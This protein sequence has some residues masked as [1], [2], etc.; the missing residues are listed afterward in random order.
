MRKPRHNVANRFSL[1][2]L[3]RLARQRRYPVKVLSL[4]RPIEVFRQELRA[5]L[6]THGSGLIVDCSRRGTAKTIRRGNEQPEC[7]TLATRLCE[8]GVNVRSTDDVFRPIRLGLDSPELARLRASNEIDSGIGAPSLWPFGPEQ[9][10]VKNGAI[11]RR[12]TQVSLYESL[13]CPPLLVR[14]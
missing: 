7:E 5:E 11:L 14:L 1:V 6:E 2:P 12:G 10:V 9:D 8:K 4:F 3:R 13:E